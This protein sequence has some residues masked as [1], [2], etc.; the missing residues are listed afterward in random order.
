MARLGR[1]TNFGNCSKP[2]SQEAISVPDGA[3]FVCPE[4]RSALRET[5]QPKSNRTI[6]AVAG[7]GAVLLAAV[8]LLM[9][10]GTGGGSNKGSITPPPTVVAVVTSTTPPATPP[11]HVV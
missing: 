2:Q 3:D 7:M 10:G 9:R 11:S 1:C 4:C 6:I 5:A 8:V